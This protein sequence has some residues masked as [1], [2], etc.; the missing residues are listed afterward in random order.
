MKG[1][2]LD[3]KCLRNE[4]LILINYLMADPNALPFFYQNEG[5]FKGGEQE[6]NFLEILLHYAT[7]DEQNFYDKPSRVKG[8]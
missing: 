2:K 4:L 5:K 6:F 8:T 3:D 7:I 1:Y